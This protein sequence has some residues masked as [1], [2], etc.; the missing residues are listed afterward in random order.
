[1]HLLDKYTNNREG[2]N[3]MQFNF[4]LIFQSFSDKESLLW[5]TQVWVTMI[6]RGLDAPTDVTLVELLKLERC[7]LQAPCVVLPYHHELGT[8]SEL[9]QLMCL[10]RVGISTWRRK[11]PPPLG[12][13]SPQ[14]RAT[15]WP[16]PPPPNLGR[17]DFPKFS[18]TFA[19]GVSI[20]LLCIL[21]DLKEV[22]DHKV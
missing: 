14:H 17:F 2:C 22:S 16:P 3:L 20:I 4:L 19:P 11:P 15:H 12:R 10:T 9:T 13:P 8:V 5:S 6:K 18:L 1:M 7:S 21:K